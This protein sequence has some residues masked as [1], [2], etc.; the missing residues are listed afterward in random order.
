M[1]ITAIPYSNLVSNSNL[2]DPAGVSITSGA[3]NRGQIPAVPA[4]NTKVN[5]LPE[6]TLLRVVNGSSAGNVVVKAGA[7]P[8]ALAAGQGDLTVAVGANAT[9]WVGP[10]ESGRF[11]QSDGSLLVETT[12]TMTITA[13]RVP[14]NT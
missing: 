10:F 2:A 11:L 4:A 7:T 8:P 6:L 9:L 12:Q 3:A 1:A 5:A 14:R 13:F